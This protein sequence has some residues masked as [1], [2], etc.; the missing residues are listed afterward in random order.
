[1]KT[2]NYTYTF[3]NYNLDVSLITNCLIMHLFYLA[4]NHS[5]HFSELLKN[6]KLLKNY[7]Y[8]LSRDTLVFILM[9]NNKVRMATFKNDREAT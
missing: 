3:N 2:A 6:K 4:N 9:H 7:F 1:M 5:F 8:S